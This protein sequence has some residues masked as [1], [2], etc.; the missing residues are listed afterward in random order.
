MF[1]GGFNGATA[2]FPDKVRDSSYVPP[3]VLTDLRLL[4]S[5]MVPG[6]QSVLKKS[7]TYTDAI[8]LTHKQNMFS[9]EFSGLSYLDPATNRYRYILEG[10]NQFLDGRA[11]GI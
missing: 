6:N 7:I 2:V 8:T 9:I 3:L 11:P 1:F 10:L 4:G 5:D